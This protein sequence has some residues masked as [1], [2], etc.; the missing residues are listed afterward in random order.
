MTLRETVHFYMTDYRT[1]LGRGIDLFIISLNLLVVAIFV[2]NTYQPSPEIKEILWRVE[3]AA[4]GLFIIEFL[5]RLYGAPNRRKHLANVYSIIDL[6]AIFPTLAEIVLPHF[7]KLVSLGFLK[8]V[9][10]LAVLR[11]FRFM[12]FFAEDHLL[13]G[14]IASDVLR[15]ARL[16]ITILLIFFISSGLFYYVESP[17]NPNVQNFG[18]AFY[19]T[20]VA[21]STVGFGDIVPITE[22]G[23]FVTVLMI[24]SGIMLIPWQ[25]S[26]I[27]R[28]W[29]SISNKK[30][31]VCPDCGLAHHELDAS[32][33]KHCGHVLYHDDGD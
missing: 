20:V 13:F 4:I 32:H 5:V 6:I 15:V 28:E 25:A 30:S 19:F 16:I 21:L 1:L 24:I 8:T 9:R 12:R 29:F 3:V 14:H 31:I 23:R 10:A 33:C 2:A 11:I 7:G 18:D 17:V 26:R 27:V 22:G